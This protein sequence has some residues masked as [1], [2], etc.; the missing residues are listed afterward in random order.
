MPKSALLAGR[1]RLRQLVNERPI[2]YE[3]LLPFLSNFFDEL[4]KRNVD[5][6]EATELAIE[7]G[8]I[9]AEGNLGDGVDLLLTAGYRRFGKEVA[10]EFSLLCQKNDSEKIEQYCLQL[11]QKLEE[12]EDVF[13]E[14]VERLEGSAFRP[15]FELASKLVGRLD[16]LEDDDDDD[17]EDDEDDE[18]EWDKEERELKERNESSLAKLYE[19]VGRY[20][21]AFNRRA[22]NECLDLCDDM[23]ELEDKEEEFSSYLDEKGLSDFSSLCDLNEFIDCCRLPVYGRVFAQERTMFF[24]AIEKGEFF[25]AQQILSRWQ[26]FEKSEDDDDEESHQFD[27][28]CLAERLIF[29]DLGEA[30]DWAERILQSAKKLVNANAEPWPYLMKEA[31]KLSQISQELFFAFDEG[32]DFQKMIDLSRQ[33][34]KIAARWFSIIEEPEDDDEC[35]DDYDDDYDDE[36]DDDYDDNERPDEGQSKDC[37]SNQ[38]E[39]EFFEN[40]LGVNSL[41]FERWIE[42][43]MDDLFPESAWFMAQKPELAKK[44][45]INWSNFLEANRTVIFMLEESLCEEE[46]IEQLKDWAQKAI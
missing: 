20:F 40:E 9:L 5:E 24:G 21:P 28:Q 30:L 39:R 43:L 42:F 38:R 33:G 16:E 31:C 32:R 25:I 19:F 22:Y 18:D 44:L 6:D 29:D 14:V 11:A 27:V 34:M 46:L 41:F 13:D 23:A 36:C 2:A 10:H 12:Q 1:E 35:D 45:I 37:N 4:A 7:Q 8:L 26:G 17:D 3:T 15:L